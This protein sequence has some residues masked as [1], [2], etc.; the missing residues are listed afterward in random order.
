[1]LNNSIL[2][3]EHLKIIAIAVHFAVNLDMMVGSGFWEID[4]RY[5]TFSAA[6][7]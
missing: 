1:M 4:I 2:Y 3:S 5:V 7:S 6:L